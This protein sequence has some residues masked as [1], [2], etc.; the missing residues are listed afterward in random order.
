MKGNLAPEGSVVKQSAVS[1][2]ARVFRG[3]ARVFESE[4]E[5]MKA[6][7]A[8]ETAEGTVVVVRREGPRGGP[9]MRE[10][11]S[12]T[13]AIVGMGLSDAVA[14]ITDGRFSG[15]TRGPCVG[16]VSPEA[17]AGGPIALV[18][19]GDEI[20]IDIPARKIELCVPEKEMKARRAAW[21]PPEPKVARGWLLRYASLVGSAAGGAVLER[22]L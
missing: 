11:L 6:I 19:D 7:L 15:G 22:R 16:H 10:M 20:L 21:K 4:E 9:G 17:A 13:A 1:E 12:P 18:E 3:R 14:L 8:R 5:A 2:K